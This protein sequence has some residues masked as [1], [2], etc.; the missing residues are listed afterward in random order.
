M[1]KRFAVALVRRESSQVQAGCRPQRPG[2]S[3]R[4]GSMLQQP[5][6]SREPLSGRRAAGNARASRNGTASIWSHSAPAC[7]SAVGR[8]SLPRRR[9]AV[10]APR[11]A[12][13]PAPRLLLVQGSPS[14]AAAAAGPAVAVLLPRGG[15]Q[16]RPP[17]APRARPRR[18]HALRTW[19]RPALP[20]DAHAQDVPKLSVQQ[21]E[22]PVDR[23]AC[24]SVDRHVGTGVEGS[25]E[26]AL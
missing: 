12:S 6:D 19:P 4:Q 3:C 24:L 2:R 25:G 8:A 11:P 23:L 20:A 16:P 18:L 13:A 14:V 5:L 21:A 10:S 22:P 1:L 9:Q 7:S 17:P 15:S 26:P